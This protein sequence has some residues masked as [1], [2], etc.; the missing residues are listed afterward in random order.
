VVE[1]ACGTGLNF[2]LIEQKV[3]PQGRIVGVDISDS[4]LAQAQHRIDTNGW[5]NISLVHADAAEFDF[6][7]GVDGIL[8]TYAHSLLPDPGH[9]IAHGAAAL[10]AGGRWVVL[11]LKIPDGTPR[12]LTRLG[13]AVLGRATSLEEWTVLRPW[14]TIRVTM[15]DTLTDLSWTDL[16]LGTEYL[17]VGSHR[18]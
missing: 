18:L 15:R 8:A 9:I 7:T 14:E 10:A 13:I 1:V 2:P 16:F 5:S 3:G 4:M 17:T 6:P 12:W 11:D